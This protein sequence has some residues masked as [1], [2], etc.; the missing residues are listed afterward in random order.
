VSGLRAAVEALADSYEGRIRAVLG[1][2]GEVPATTFSAPQ[3][4]ADL[5]ALLAAEDDP[6]PA[7]VWEQGWNAGVGYEEQRWRAVCNVRLDSIVGALPS[8]DFPPNPYPRE[9]S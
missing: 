7:E 9:T 1:D 6:E 3:V 8:D 5:R 2:G 4:V